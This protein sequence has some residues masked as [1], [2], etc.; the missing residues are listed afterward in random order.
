MLRKY[1]LGLV[2][3]LAGFAGPA[4]A[5][6]KPFYS[7]GGTQ[8][9]SG[10]IATTGTFQDIFTSG[11]R[12]N[13]HIQN[14]SLHT[15]YVFFG[16]KANATEDTSF[17]LAAAASMACADSGVVRTD[18]VSITGTQNDKFYADQEN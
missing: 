9:A 17:T 2:L 11:G 14:N 8:N 3:A 7:P 16:L 12:A 5:S 4:H 15:M 6:E 18:E 10:A 1:V 13:C